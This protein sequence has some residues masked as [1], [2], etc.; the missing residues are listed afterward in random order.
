MDTVM[1]SL[2]EWGDWLLESLTSCCGPGE[3]EERPEDGERER[4]LGETDR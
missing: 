1:D 4:L 2:R 3:R